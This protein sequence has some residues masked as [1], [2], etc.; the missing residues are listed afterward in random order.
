MN[1]LLIQIDDQL[2]EKDAKI[3]D[4]TNTVTA[5]DAMIKSLRPPNIFDDLEYTPWLVAQGAAANT[6]ASGAVAGGAQSQPAVTSAWFS[7]SPT[8]PYSNR[9]HYKRFGTGFSSE[10][11]FRPRGA[12]MFPSVTDAA[13]CQAI[14]FDLQQS[15][16]GICFNFG[17]QF[18][19]AEGTFRFWDRNSSK[20]IIAAA[21]INLTRPAPMAWTTCVFDT[22]RDD[23]NI[24]YD[25]C[26]ING[27]PITFTTSP[28]FPAP[29]LGLGD[30]LNFAFQ[31]DGNKNGDPYRVYVN[32][33]RLTTWG[34]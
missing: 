20:W 32:R 19:Y 29:I 25:S 28:V 8:G 11:I 1:S 13:R 30:M 9:Y 10:N 26:S 5:Q 12:F 7:L 3:Q 18:D 23:T 14:E 21:Q 27:K 31:M 17:W 15:I 22:H 16:D 34:R 6:G 2:N 24:Y 33:M 4:L